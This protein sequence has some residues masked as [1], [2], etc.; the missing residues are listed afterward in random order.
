VDQKSKALLVCI[1]LFISGW[2]YAQKDVDMDSGPSF[3]DR[4][5]VG[6]GLGFSSSSYSTY[7]SLSPVAGYML[8]RKLSVGV[9]LTYQYYKDK[10]NDADDHR[11]GGNVYVMQM[12]IY[13]VF[14]IGQYN[15]INLSR[16]PH[17]EGYPRETFTR[18]L[19]GGGVSQPM[20]RANLNIMAMYDVTHD[21]N[22]PYGSPWVIGMFI[23]I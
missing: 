21:S 15:V 5:Y 18:F 7:L 12:L 2:S 16:A 20:G 1:L 11:Y 14:V 19:I 23:S 13:N 9:G 10:F 3:K 8:T 4:I 6:G 17:I 22:S